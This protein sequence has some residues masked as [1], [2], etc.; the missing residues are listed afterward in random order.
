M[1]ELLKDSPPP[2]PPFAIFSVTGAKFEPLLLALGVG[3]SEDEMKTLLS[4]KANVKGYQN[5]F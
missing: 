3:T 4:P 5:I 1:N 2:P